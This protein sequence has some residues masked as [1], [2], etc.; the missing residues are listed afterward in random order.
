MK[1]AHLADCHLGA[2]RD[3]ALREANVACF[4]GVIQQC[5]TDKVDFILISGDLLN[6][7]FPPLEIQ[8]RA[9]KCFRKLQ[10]EGIRVYLIPG[11]HDLTV[12]G[13]TWLDVLDNAGLVV[14]VA[15]DGQ[16]RIVKD[17]TG[18]SI[19]GVM[20]LRGGLDK[21]TY[22]QLDR[23]ALEIVP[24]PK[25][26][27]FHALIAELKTINVEGMPLSL[28]P[29]GFDYYAGGH[30]HE[31]QIKDNVVYPGPLFP[32]SISELEQTQHGSYM[33]VEDF[34]AKK[35]QL[36]NNVVKL[37]VGCDG[38][39]PE[40]VSHNMLD[41]VG[42][43]MQNAIVCLRLEGVM[44][45]PSKVKFRSF[46]DACKQAG[47]KAVLRNTTKLESK[48]LAEFKMPDNEDIEGSLLKEKA[49]DPDLARQWLDALALE[50]QDGET[51]TAYEARVLEEAKRLSVDNGPSHAQ[52][53]RQDN[54]GQQGD[55][56]PAAD[57]Q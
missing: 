14:N 31:S 24:G 46:V 40:Q 21:H 10:Q 57:N 37:S 43:N 32:N 34:V 51:K 22:E 35:V 26:F 38:L 42:S 27:M 30:V 17:A 47:A 55:E 33:L 54:E 20:G 41:L 8:K 48:S 50:M 39:L 16:A 6:N 2:W 53:A 9:A 5:I 15:R 12:G 25:I 52:D 13:K 44:D 4:E 56:N 1:F 3:E 19:A 23:T 49:S 36:P 28:L 45:N 11:S 29:R 7:P 18:V